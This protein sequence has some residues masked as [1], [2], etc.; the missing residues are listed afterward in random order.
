MTTSFASGSTSFGDSSL[1][2]HKFTGSVDIKGDLSITNAFSA[3]SLGMTNIVTN[4]IPYFNGSILDDSEIYQNSSNIA[5][6][7]T[8]AASKLHIHGDLSASGN[9]RMNADSELT[10]NHLTP[11][12]NF[13]HYNSSLNYLFYK[14]DKHMFSGEIS[15]SAASGLMTMNKIGIGIPQSSIPGLS[16]SFYIQTS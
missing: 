12:D 6:G 13:I 10:F 1:D 16:G 3:A 9:V 14:S 11:T 2:K 8:T 7:G 4:R 5:I 15:S